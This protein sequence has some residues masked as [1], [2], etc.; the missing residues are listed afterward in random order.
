[1]SLG[2]ALH[3]FEEDDLERV[4]AAAME[5]W[6]QSQPLF[7]QKSPPPACQGIADAY[8]ERLGLMTEQVPVSVSMTI[9][10]SSRLY[11]IDS[12]QGRKQFKRPRVSFE[13]INANQRRL[14]ATTTQLN[15]A[16][17]QI[18]HTSGT[19]L[20]QDLAKLRVSWV[21]VLRD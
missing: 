11:S 15:A 21:G 1:M 2:K 7:L 4:T 14:Q 13:R 17:E 12:P 9:M 18:V 6:R 8:S 10:I 3:S 20:P 16:L 19:P 5:Q